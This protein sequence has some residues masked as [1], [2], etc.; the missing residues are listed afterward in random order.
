MA[1]VEKWSKEAIVWSTPLMACEMQTW[2]EG[3]DQSPVIVAPEAQK[4]KHDRFEFEDKSE[5]IYRVWS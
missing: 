2:I 1:G 5:D 4:R 3:G